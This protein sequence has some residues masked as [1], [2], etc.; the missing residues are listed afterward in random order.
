MFRILIQSYTALLNRILVHAFLFLFW[1]F[2]QC[3]I[4]K[5]EKKCHSEKSQL[6]LIEIEEE[7]IHFLSVFTA[8]ESGSRRASPM[9]PDPDTK[10]HLPMLCWQA[11]MSEWQGIT[12]RDL[13]ERVD[14]L[15][16]INP[17]EVSQTK[18]GIS[19]LFYFHYFWDS[20]TSIDA[21]SNLNFFLVPNPNYGFPAIV[22]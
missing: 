4:K 21:S 9:D 12:I 17:D 6:E 20:S 7:K 13:L 18:A 16:F 3:C 22:P 1:T 15:N 8:V 5:E 14:L 10:T 2:Y 11:I 19:L